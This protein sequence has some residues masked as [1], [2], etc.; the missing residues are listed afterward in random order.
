MRDAR[1]KPSKHSVKSH[2]RNRKRVHTYTRGSG[3]PAT[4][5][6]AEPKIIR[7]IQYPEKKLHYGSGFIGSKYQRTR[8][9]PLKDVAKMIKG[10]ILEKYPFIKVSV[11]TK[12]FS[13]GR[14]VNVRITSYP[15]TFL[16]KKVIYPEFEH[17]PVEKVPSY[18]WGYPYD[19]DADAVVK[20]IRKI[21]DSYNYDDSDSQ[22]DHFDT[23]FYG[24]VT[25]AWELQK[26]ETNRLGLN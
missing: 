14:E 10:E 15:K 7:E 3:K 22:I 19:D 2:I 13:G 25:F 8:N 12:H 4:K 26:K 5:P 20:G 11:S 9:L 24:D 21:I 23:S 16:V 18:A 17:L 1:K 6:K